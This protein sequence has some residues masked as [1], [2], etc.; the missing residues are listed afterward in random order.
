[1]ALI[2]LDMWCNDFLVVQGRNAYKKQA[3]LIA[4]EFN[5]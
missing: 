4:A 3:R 1:M 2:Y 5:E